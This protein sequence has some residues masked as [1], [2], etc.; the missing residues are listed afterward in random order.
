M[1]WL[2]SPKGKVNHESLTLN[3][4]LLVPVVPVP[5]AVVLAGTG[6][7][8]AA[9]TDGDVGVAAVNVCHT[10]AAAGAEHLCL[11][12]LLYLYFGFQIIVLFHCDIVFGVAALKILQNLI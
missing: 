11:L 5:A 9:A 6:T 1:A 3:H 4:N 10:A 2:D 8:V 12:N 7:T